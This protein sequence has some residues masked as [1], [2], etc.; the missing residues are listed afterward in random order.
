LKFRHWALKLGVPLAADAIDGDFLPIAMASGC[1]GLM[2]R[3]YTVLRQSSSPPYEWVNVDLLRA[4]MCK[5]VA[6][7]RAP[8]G[9]LAWDDWEIHC[10]LA[11]IALT[12]TDYTRGFPLVGPHKVW[13]MLPALLPVLTCKCIRFAEGGPELEPDATAD[14]LYGAVYAN[15][16]A[17]HVTGARQ[18]TVVTQRLSKSRLS[19]K[20]KASIP[21]YSRASCT[22][23]NASFVLAYWLV[24]EPDSMAPRYGF[25]ERGGVVEW[26]D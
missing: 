3:R 17:A 16:F 20:T 14:K 6:Q 1:S 19:E 11:L 8:A 10:L 7:T 23:R 12:G 2:V 5:A 26:D 18:L 9:V 25:R 22:A 15:A 13:K 21:T 24:L 4:G